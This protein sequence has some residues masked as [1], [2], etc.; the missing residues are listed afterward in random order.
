MKETGMMTAEIATEN[1]RGPDR[2]NRMQENALEVSELLKTLANPS[3]LLILCALM[4]EPLSVSQIAEHVPN[5][6]QSALSQNLA[7][8]RSVGIL[9]SEKSGLSV[10]YSI[11]DTRIFNVMGVLEMYYCGVKEEV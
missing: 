3:R 1:S 11:D 9:R 5:I 10:I 6:S 4:R 2:F 8:M 7:R